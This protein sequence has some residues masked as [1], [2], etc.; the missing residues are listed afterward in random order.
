MIKTYIPEL[1]TGTIA[2]YM[3]QWLFGATVQLH[4]MAQWMIQNDPISAFDQ[5]VLFSSS[6]GV[7]VMGLYLLIGV[8]CYGLVIER[9]GLWAYQ[10]YLKRS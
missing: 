10:K 3:F 7:L 1:I 6:L 5:S 8:Y 9:I 2:L 4:E